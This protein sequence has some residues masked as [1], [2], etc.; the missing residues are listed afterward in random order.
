MAHLV[1]ISHEAKVSTVALFEEMKA[2][3]LNM[4]LQTV[5]GIENGSVVGFL[6]DVRT[7]EWVYI[8]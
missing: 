6:A 4:L 5:F 3:E 2:E 8:A 7:A 1:K